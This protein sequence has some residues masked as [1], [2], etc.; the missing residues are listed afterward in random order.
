MKFSI[1]DLAF[2]GFRYKELVKLDKKY[3]IEIFYEFGKSY[4]WK[5][6]LPL[7]LDKREGAF[8][9]HGPCVAVNLAD[10]NNKNYILA[11]AQAFS[12]ADEYNAKFLVVHTNEEW[13]GDSAVCKKLIKERLT[14]L[15]QMSYINNIVM[16]I[17]NVGLKTTGTLLFDE[18]EYLALLEEFP[19]AGVLLDI[20][21]A[22]VNG[23]DISK[24]IEKL[25][26]RIVGIHLHDNDG[27]GDQH[28]PIGEGTIEWQPIFRAIEK[29]A[30]Q[31]HLVLEYAKFDLDNLEKHIEFVSAIR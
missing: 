15:Q 10:K 9:I 11:F 29:Y 2:A 18:D 24:V 5:K 27:K 12:C 16:A 1:S 13:D 6:V 21:H 8:S 28:L 25:G 26:K 17:E 7:L 23:W 19:N 3:G 20:G 14:E 30:P 31:A 22:N 4:Y